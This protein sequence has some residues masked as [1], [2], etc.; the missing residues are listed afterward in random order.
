MSKSE[1]VKEAV[2]YIAR[3]MK[4]KDYFSVGEVCEGSSNCYKFL[5][6]TFVSR[7]VKGMVEVYMVYFPSSDSFSVSMKAQKG[8]LCYFNGEDYFMARKGESAMELANTFLEKC[9][10]LTLNGLSNA[11]EESESSIKESFRECI[12]G[13]AYL[14]KEDIY[15]LLEPLR[16]FTSSESILSAEKY[17][18]SLRD[19]INQNHSKTIELNNLK[20]DMKRGEK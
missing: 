5:V 6:E 3:E 14:P 12:K 1:E 10:L 16:V 20:I 9:D 2:E 18:D 17:I 4:K 19:L 13:L 7:G 15:D 8:A 11:I